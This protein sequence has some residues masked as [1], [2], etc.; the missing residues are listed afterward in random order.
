MWDGQGLDT[1]GKTK[2][3]G[4]GALRTGQ[5]VETRTGGEEEEREG[6][7]AGGE[8]SLWVKR[9]SSSGWKGLG[10]LDVADGF[11]SSPALGR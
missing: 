1:D 10:R 3:L 2:R 4:S 5:S 11:C 6:K 7:S 9:G 8:E